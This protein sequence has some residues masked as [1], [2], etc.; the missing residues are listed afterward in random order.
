[1]STNTAAVTPIQRA[2]DVNHDWTFGKGLGN[3]YQGNSAIGQDCDTRLLMFLNDCFFDQSAWIDWLNILGSTNQQGLNLAI[4]G[5]LI[6]T[7]GV[8][9]ILQLSTAIDPQT[10]DIS[11]SYSVNTIYSVYSNT[12]SLSTNI[13]ASGVANAQ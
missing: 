4:S 5:I 3:Y 11:V 12:V 9:S 2:L 1:M 8:T 7:T 6:G 10:R 13:Q